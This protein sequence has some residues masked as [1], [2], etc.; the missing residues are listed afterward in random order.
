MIRLPWNDTNGPGVMLEVTDACNID[1]RVCYRTRGT[2]FKSLSRVEVE[3]ITAIKLRSLHTVAISGGEPTLHPELCQIVEMIKRHGFHV[4]LLT[5]GVLID[6]QYLQ[7]LKDSGLDSILFHV[8]CGQDR[9]DLPAPPTFTDVQIRLKELTRMASSFAI[10]VSISLTL[11]DDEA[12]ADYSRFFFDSEDIT[13]LFI[14]RAIDVRQLSLKVN[15]AAKKERAGLTARTDKSTVERIA[16]FYEQEYGI[17]PFAFIPSSDEKYTTWLSFFIPIVYSKHGNTLFRIRS[18]FVDSWLLEIPRIVLGRYIHK[19]KQNFVIT[20]LRTLLN[21][22]STLRLYYS[23]RFLSRALSPGAKLKHKMIV[24]D[25]GPV[26][27]EGGKLIHCKYCPTA[28]I[29][30][31]KVLPCCTADYPVP[32]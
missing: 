3:L 12:L 14:A 19:T 20:L 7:R 8:D 16:E 22:L 32:S 6:Q 15:E 5:N 31:G 13:F 30:D 17:E 24:Y 26:V 27:E 18:N 1:C 29:R 11:Y 10:D 21:G 4:F 25:H 28:T 2:S 9:P 23:A